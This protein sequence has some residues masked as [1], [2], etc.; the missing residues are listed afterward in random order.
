VWVYQFDILHVIAL[1]HV[2][3][4]NL[5]VSDE[6]GESDLMCIA[7]LICVVWMIVSCLSVLVDFLLIKGIR[8]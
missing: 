4:G 6:S 1:L 5:S 8:I 7:N 2:G 3:N